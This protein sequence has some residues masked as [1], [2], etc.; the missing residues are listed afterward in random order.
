VSQRPAVGCLFEVVETLVLTLV[1]FLGIQTFVAQPYKVQ[2]ESM[3]TTLLPEQ[4]VLVDKLT[5]HWSAY[6]HGDIV[7]F[8][9]P[10]SWSGSNGVPFIKRIIGLPG[11]RVELRDGLVYVNNVKL[12]EPYIYKD[13]GVPQSSDPAGGG[14]TQWLV[15]DG[16]LFVMGD[17]RHN[18]ADSRVFGPIP[19]SSVI[20]RAWLRYWPFDTFGILPTPSHPELSGSPAAGPGPSPTLATAAP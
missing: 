9:P 6:T 8:D 10:A 14:A 3:E 12:D 5:P 1:I 11:D 2:Q 4:Y 16:D 7:V 20:G 13:D 19:I 17:H 15:P 18:S